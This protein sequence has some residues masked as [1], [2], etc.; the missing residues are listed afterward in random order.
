MVTNRQALWFLW[1]LIGWGIAVLIH[2]VALVLEGPLSGKWEERKIAQLMEK[3]RSSWRS[4]PP[5]PQ[6]P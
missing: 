1:P 3:E 2:G 5:R 4:Q 6:A